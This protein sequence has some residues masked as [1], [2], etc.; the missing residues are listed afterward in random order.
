[1]RIVESCAIMY[2]ITPGRF[3][4]RIKVL[5]AERDCSGEVQMRKPTMEVDADTVRMSRLQYSLGYLASRLLFN[6]VEDQGQGF[7]TIPFLSSWN[8]ASN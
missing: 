1:M 6:I 4:P 3:P 7:R 2:M 5:P 8:S